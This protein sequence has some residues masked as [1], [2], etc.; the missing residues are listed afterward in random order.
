[1]SFFDKIKSHHLDI[2]KEVGNIGAGNAATALSK[3]LG[4]TIDMTVPKVSVVS[5]D[6]MMDLV[7]GSENVIASV[8]LRIEGDAPGSMYFMLPLEQAEKFV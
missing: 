7:G 8:F 2:L 1:M 4:K 5:F 3:I 6:E